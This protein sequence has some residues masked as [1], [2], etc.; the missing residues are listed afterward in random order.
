MARHLYTAV[1]FYSYKSRDTTFSEVSPRSKFFLKETTD[2]IGASNPQTIN[3]PTL[4]NETG[5]L[6]D[7]DNVKIRLYRTVNNGDV[8][9]LVSELANNP[10]AST[11]AF[12][13]AVT[14][15]NLQATG[16]T[17]YTTAVGVLDS[18]PPPE[19]AKYIA[20]AGDYT[21]YAIDNKV[22]QSFKGAP[23]WVP[24][25]F[26]INLPEEITG[27]SSLFERVIVFC[28]K[29]AYRIDGYFDFS[30]SEA[31][32]IEISK[33]IG[34]RSNKSIVKVSNQIYCLGV[35][36]IYRVN[37]GEAVNV[38]PHLST[39]F[40]K[41]ISN[42]SS[43]NHIIG[44]Y[45]NIDERIWFNI[46]D[47][48]D[49]VAG[50]ILNLRYAQNPLVECFTSISGTSNF[51][52]DSGGFYR[53]Y[54]LRAD[55]RGFLFKHSNE[56][57]N[58]L[59]APDGKSIESFQKVPTKVH[60]LSGITDLGENLIRKF[61][62]R[63]S[64]QLNK[65]FNYSLELNAYNDSESQ[66]RS[67]VSLVNENL[68]VFMKNFVFKAS[69]YL[70]YRPSNIRSHSRFFPGD[71]GLRA[72]HMQIEIKSGDQ[73]M[74]TSETYGELSFNGKSSFLI[75]KPI[76]NFENLF[77]PKILVLTDND[78][79]DIGINQTLRQNKGFILDGVKHSQDSTYS[80]SNTLNDNLTGNYKYI[81]L[82]QHLNNIVNLIGYSVE[83]SYGG[84]EFSSVP[85][86]NPVTR[87]LETS[88]GVNGSSDQ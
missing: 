53:G 29:S 49:N 4:V 27:L 33:T 16:D 54:V 83:Y 74:G 80:F 87:G 69:R 18:T 50:I 38:S 8:F 71:G 59:D 20:V 34:L 85:Y 39:F 3:V 82:G 42:T 51:Y 2:P 61:I 9:Y 10:M 24:S 73:V 48:S 67:L 22:Y 6:R 47:E 19:N 60:F 35:D 79:F 52:F 88:S 28:E 76:T 86:R 81:I 11:V 72:N 12:T 30:G 1:Y 15:A 17:I 37:L 84:D 45:D 14:D 5:D 68:T 23:S 32:E 13:D 58:D 36:G 40:D 57:I 65:L 31:Q 21:Y 43:F 63:I 64:V 77:D 62:P 26:V 7:V 41:V 55:N 66:K 56:Y 70:G 78:Y 25:N 46:R 75:K 44:V